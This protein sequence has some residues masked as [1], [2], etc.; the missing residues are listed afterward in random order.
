MNT[1]PMPIALTLPWPIKAL[2]PNARVHFMALAKAKKAYRNACYIQARRQGILAGSTQLQGKPL[3]IHL[4]F[5]PPTKHP[6][7]EDNLVASMKSGLDGL[8]DALGV[9]DNQ[10]H[11]THAIA[12]EIGGM[13][14]VTIN[15]K[16]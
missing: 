4:E 11:L 1:Q 3:A 12:Q 8:A 2:S 7:D 9:D 16:D 13:V 15:T 5:V 10:F 6:R 14:R